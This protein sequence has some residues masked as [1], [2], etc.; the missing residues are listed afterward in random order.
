MSATKPYTI[1]G[2]ISAYSIAV[3]PRLSP[4][5]LRTA[6]PRPAVPLILRNDGGNL[7][8]A[9]SVSNRFRQMLSDDL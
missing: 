4:I 7:R 6:L 9:I 5:S 2:V 3:T 8:N 1:N